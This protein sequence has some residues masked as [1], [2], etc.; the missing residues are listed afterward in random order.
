METKSC[1]QGDG[2]GRLAVKRHDLFLD[3]LVHLIADVLRQLVAIEERKSQQETREPKGAALDHCND[4]EGIPDIP[5][6]DWLLP[7]RVLG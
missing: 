5:Q 7:R 4:A 2:L 3:G 6:P 1:R